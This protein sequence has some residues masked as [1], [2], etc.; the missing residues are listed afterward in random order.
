MKSKNNLLYFLLCFSV[1]VYLL[2]RDALH[3]I[4]AQVVGLILS[5]LF[6]IDDVLF[7]FFPSSSSS[8]SSLSNGKQQQEHNESKEEIATLS[9]YQKDAIL[10]SKRIIKAERERFL[11]DGPVPIASLQVQNL[12]EKANQV[13][14]KNLDTNSSAEGQP[15][16]LQFENKERNIKI[17]SAKF[18]NHG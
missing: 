4:I 10:A 5:L 16:I 13:F 11:K 17:Y 1:L 2:K 9:E 7:S 12:L 3:F 14:E 15:W 6:N 8:S 18:P